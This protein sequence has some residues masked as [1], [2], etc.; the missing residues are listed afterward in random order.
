L[1]LA[2]EHT[3]TRL[4]AIDIVSLVK[5]TVLPLAD[6]LAVRV[7]VRKVADVDLALLQRELSKAFHLSANPVADIGLSEHT[8][9]CRDLRRG[10]LILQDVSSTRRAGTFRFESTRPDFL[11]VAMRL[12]LPDL[13][14]VEGFIWINKL[15]VASQR[16]LLR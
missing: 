2:E 13:P 6:S 14:N 15:S 7:P 1:L 4:E 12:A 9:V 8:V 16:V 11:T 3:P 10:L 5:V